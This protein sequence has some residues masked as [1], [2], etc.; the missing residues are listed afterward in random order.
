MQPTAQIWILATNRSEA[1]RKAADAM[2]SNLATAT[3]RPRVT[4]LNP[5][6]AG[7]ADNSSLERI[8]ARS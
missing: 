6:S 2:I 8:G 7:K 5:G 4:G 3:R 1:A